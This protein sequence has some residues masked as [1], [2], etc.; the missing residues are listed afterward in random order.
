MKM[1][2]W[3]IGPAD[4]NAVPAHWLLNFEPQMD[5]S[6]LNFLLEYLN[7]IILDSINFPQDKMEDNLNCLHSFF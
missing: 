3:C 4:S 6:S 7:Y 1:E 5:P 2:S